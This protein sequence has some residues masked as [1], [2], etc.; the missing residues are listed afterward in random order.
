MDQ[1]FSRFPVL[2]TLLW[3][4][5]GVA[6]FAAFL[7]IVPGFFNNPSSSTAA[8]QVT[9]TP[10]ATL[11]PLKSATPVL[12]APP[13]KPETPNPIPTPPP[14]AKVFTF[15]ANLRQSGWLATGEP[16][17]HW[18]DRNIHAGQYKGQTFES[19]VYFDLAVL[20]PG[21]RILYA[22][23]ELTGLDRGNLGPSGAWAL[24][25][26][27]STLLTGWTSHSTSDFVQSP[28]LDQI[29]PLLSPADLAE[30]QTNRFT[31]SANQLSRLEQSLHQTGEIAFRLD[32]PQGPEESLFTWDGGDPDP[33]VGAHPTM[34]V[35]AIPGQ[36]LPI[37]NTPTPQNVLTAAAQFVRGTESAKLSGTPTPL[38]RAYATYNPFQ[39]IT[40]QPTPANSATAQAQAAYAT[41][42][43]LTTGTFTPTP[44]YWVTA[45]PTL[46][47]L[48]AYQ[49]TPIPSPTPTSFVSR[50]QLL[51]TPIPTEYGLSG[52]IAFLTDREGIG[53]PQVWVMRPDGSILGKLSGDEFYQIAENRALFSPDKKYQVDVGKNDNGLWQIVMLDTVKGVL[54]PL[55]QESPNRT[56]GEG[57][58][59]P[60]WSPL[61]DK[62]AYVS[63][64]TRTGE[65]YV[66]DINTKISTQLTF[67]PLNQKT[68]VL[69]QNNHPSW[70]PDGKQIIFA[71]NRD[72]YPLWQIWIMDANGGNMRRLSS[73]PYNDNA[74]V[75]IR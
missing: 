11:T 2:E 65:I 14:N 41:A 63:D 60:A 5:A 39:V 56:T 70:S 55:I 73:S 26:L 31:F 48:T 71:S 16:D 59:Q 38:P 9:L 27:P 15:V 75:W 51:Q 28:T 64:Q 50:L 69:A 18:G 42:V 66:Y 62:I 22:D 3:I 21:S 13:P 23:V 61:G 40:S 44:P 47:L 54:A 20:A 1:L 46:V 30:G 19:L 72:P 43:A 12:A 10:R 24:K 33:G 74:P 58:Y 7:I 6:A 35:I 34:R 49:F 29:G 4:L 37:T 52:K 8:S 67:T 57:S 25:W 32:G 17:P 36:F 53:T 68:W 45:T